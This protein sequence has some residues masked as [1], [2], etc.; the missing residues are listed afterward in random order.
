MSY[1]S[2]PTASQNYSPYYQQ[3][4]N[5]DRRSQYTEQSRGNNAYQQNTYQPLSAYQTNQPA[6]SAPQ[7]NSSGSAYHDSVHGS[8]AGGRQDSRTKYNDVR[9]SV[10]TTALGNLAYA[11]SLGRDTSN[12][13]HT[14][15][16]NRG[17]N[18]TGYSASSSCGSSIASPIPYGSMHQRPESNNATVTSRDDHSRAQSAIA[19]PSFGYSANS[20]NTGYQ[21][22]QKSVVGQGQS[23]YASTNYQQSSEPYRVSQYSEPA[24]PS[25]GQALRRPPST[26]SSQSASPVVSSDQSVRLQS[27]GN[28][29]RASTSKRPEQPRVPTP[30]QRQTQ[31]I[32]SPSSGNQ[33]Q[34]SRNVPSKEAASTAT[35]TNAVQ[36]SNTSAQAAAKTAPTNSFHRSNHTR[37]SSDSQTNGQ[38]IQE[39]TPKVSQ[40]PTTVNPSQVFNDAEYQRRQATAAAEAEAARKKG[41]DERITAL[42]KEHPSSIPSSASGAA[43]A[44][45]KEQMEQEMKQMIEKMRD[46]KSKD[47]SLFSQIWEQVKKGQPAQQ[48]S[49]QVAPQGSSVSPVVVNDQLPS[50]VVHLPPESELSTPDAAFPPNFDRGRFPAQRRRRGGANFTPDKKQRTPKGSAKSTPTGSNLD[51]GN[52][53]MQQAM[54]E[55]HRT[56]AFPMPATQTASQASSNNYVYPPPQ[57]KQPT[58]GQGTV[59][60]SS[61]TPTNPANVQAQNVLPPNPNEAPPVSTTGPIPGSSATPTPPTNPQAPSKPSPPQSGGTYWPENKKRQ[62]AEAARNALISSPK[63]H[64]KQITADEIHQLLDQNPSYTQM[65]EIL[66]YRGFVIDRGQFARLLLSSVPDL[67]AASAQKS[68]GNPPQHSIPTVP[69]AQ[70]T[71]GPPPDQNGQGGIPRP[72]PYSAPQ[73]QPGYRYVTPYPN[74]SQP[75]QY[76]IPQAQMTQY[77]PN[78]AYI[79]HGVLYPHAPQYQTSQPPTVGHPPKPNV[80]WSDLQHQAA[81]I[82]NKPV[83]TPKQDMARKRSFGDIVD[84]TQAT[85]DDEDE[86]PNQRPRTD[87]GSALRVYAAGRSVKSG[88]A[89]PTSVKDAVSAGLEEYRYKPT[90][91]DEYLRAQ[92]IVR[93]MNKRQD[94]LRRSSYNPK[95]IARDILLAIG[96]HPTMAPLN[97][98]LDDLRERFTAVNYESDLATFRWDL[99]DPGGPALVQEATVDEDSHQSRRSS[100]MA[101]VSGGNKSS[102][103]EPGK[104]NIHKILAIA[105][106]V[107]VKV[108]AT[109]S[110][111]N[112]L[113]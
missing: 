108:Y 113:E 55:F 51:P 92:D 47:P 63:N 14:I 54:A 43:G 22:Q 90:G 1:N 112:R 89:T 7:S 93:P 11:S 102:N 40:F 62:L 111:S 2:Y 101:V 64:G 8:G 110:L 38:K 109:T 82:N 44:A 71:T 19:S 87:D 77:P 56:S 99:V 88:T 83:S 66:E 78:P 21:S 34:F 23:Q 58:S 24:R 98:H 41:Q 107:N 103:V 60:G 33:G 85:S 35:H 86:T 72:M 17:Q 67:G 50:P 5:Q 84:L 65:C 18:T 61:A 100:R 70:M 74:S 91:Q 20:G 96:K 49:P 37:T 39:S 59:P 106:A 45:K 15:G 80:R 10:D 69:T 73:S 28:Y 13:H 79:G 29:R 36:S 30:H 42:P 68:S 6:S 16:Y 81:A 3:T 53:T 95:T 31:P 27:D 48:A 26:T 104:S 52:Q 4:V 57:E 76:T 75:G 9:S 97:A 25:S 46:Y 12:L 94:A 105:N 32:A